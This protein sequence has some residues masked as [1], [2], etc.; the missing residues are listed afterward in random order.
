MVLHVQRCGAPGPWGPRERSFGLVDTCGSRSSVRVDLLQQQPSRTVCIPIPFLSACQTLDKRTI[1]TDG[2]AS[3][4]GTVRLEEERGG[5]GM[6]FFDFADTVS[7]RGQ[8]RYYSEPADPGALPRSPEIAPVAPSGVP[9]TASIGTVTIASLGDAQDASNRWRDYVPNADDEQIDLAMYGDG[10]YL[11]EEG[12]AGYAV[13]YNPVCYGAR[14]DGGRKKSKKF[15]PVIADPDHPGLSPDSNV[16]STIAEGFACLHAFEL[17]KSE[18]MMVW[19]NHLRLYNRTVKRV[20]FKFFTDSKNLL[21]TIRNMQ[22]GWWWF[23]QDYNKYDVLLRWLVG[24]IDQAARDLREW[25]EA[26]GMELVVELAWIK[27][28]IEA[29]DHP[30]SEADSL[31]T[32][33]SRDQATPSGLTAELSS[34]LLGALGQCRRLPWGPRNYRRRAAAERSAAVA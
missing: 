20:H 34:R 16:Y 22:E 10:S 31:A 4:K 15:L 25:L 5:G 27:G 8:A 2:T 24:E 12:K 17:A 11:F 23:L 13:V 28:H 33:A 1:F 26:R 6:E 18:M 29:E 30:H 9:E 32:Q 19:R 7:E 3:A 14:T 21:E